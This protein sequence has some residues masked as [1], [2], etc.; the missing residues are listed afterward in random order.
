VGV[1]KAKK[2]PRAMQY[3]L[4]VDQR[5]QRI[6][7]RRIS[8][9]LKKRPA[10]PVRSKNSLGARSSVRFQWPI[11]SGAIVIGVTCVVA[12]AA[13][14][15]A[16]QSAPGPDVDRAANVSMQ[17]TPAGKSVRAA[18]VQSA[19][20]PVAVVPAVH[21]AT[22]DAKARPDVQDTAPVTVTGCLERDGVTFWLK[23][24]SGV[25]DTSKGRSWR[26]GFLKKRSPRVGV[27]SATNAV[28]LSNYVGERVA[29]TGGLM[30]GQMR[31]RSLRRVAASCK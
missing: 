13:L 9:R 25:P 30:N 27:V 31:A 8:E 20:K 22:V 21:A 17:M 1:K 10:R 5:L 7:L 19:P 4:N 14:N 23:D 3:L 15:T 16:S 2:S 6:S 24:V 11:R 29:A 26:S 12:A 28:K 18:A